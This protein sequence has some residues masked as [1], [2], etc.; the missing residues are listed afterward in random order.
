MIM[1]RMRASAEK[2]DDGEPK[3]A[4]IQA[5]NSLDWVF[6]SRFDHDTVDTRKAAST[7]PIPK[8][9]WPTNTFRYMSKSVK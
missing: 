2:P 9:L 5:M 6:S 3:K 8:K 7:D 1:A 4:S